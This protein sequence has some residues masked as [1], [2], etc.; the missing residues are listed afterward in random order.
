MRCADIDLPPGTWSRKAA[1]LKQ[2]RDHSIPLSA[3]AR[4]LLSD[5]RAAQTA[6]RRVLPEFAF[7]GGGSTGHVVEIKR[8]W[9]I[10]AQGRRARRFEIARPTTFFRESVGVVGRESL[11]LIGALLGHSNPSTTQ[12]YA[13]MFDDP[14]RAATET[15]GA[16]IAAV[17]APRP[18]DPIPLRRPLTRK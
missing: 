1:D 15:V 3:P 14:M 9:R 2:A 5:I 16:V 8:S 6:S 18:P 12:R 7:P 13:H 17:G 4:Q 11:P 10:A